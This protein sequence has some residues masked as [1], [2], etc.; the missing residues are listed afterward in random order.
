MVGGDITTVYLYGRGCF[1][2]KSSI[3][4]QT[5]IVM[6]NEIR[7][8][9]P[10]SLVFRK[11]IGQLIS[12][13]EY[14][15]R[16]RLRIMGHKLLSARIL[17]DFRTYSWLEH[18]DVH[19]MYADVMVE[20]DSGEVVH[21]MINPVY[22]G[23]DEDWELFLCRE[24]E[25]ILIGYSTDLL[26]FPERVTFAGAVFGD[27]T[28]KLSRESLN[29]DEMVRLNREHNWTCRDID[30]GDELLYDAYEGDMDAYWS[31]RT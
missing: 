5:H 24:P 19:Y 26:G 12:Y 10:L 18:P 27:R 16:I 2:R 21:S 22:A 11:E 30:N 31:H 6:A 13:Q 9:D 20:L 14:G 4:V 1:Y 23:T 7:Y 8:A 17:N 25:D 29:L 3:F 15:L 28:Y